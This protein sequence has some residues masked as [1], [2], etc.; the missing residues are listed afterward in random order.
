MNLSHSKILAYVMLAMGFALSLIPV[1]N[2][3]IW[4]ATLPS[5]AT[6]IGIKTWRQ[7]NEEKD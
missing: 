5:V 6:I 7:T 4:L 2:P 1:A 3:S